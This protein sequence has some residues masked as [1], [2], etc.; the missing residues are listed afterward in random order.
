MAIIGIDLGTS[1]SAAAALRGG[2]PM[3]I[4]SAEGISL[5]GKSFPSYVAVTADGQMLVGEPARRQAVANP[6]G[7]ATCFKRRMGQRLAVRLQD[8]EF[9]PEQLSAFLLQKIKRYA[10]AYLGEPVVQAVV[11]V[12]AYFDDNQRSATKDACAVAGIE[13]ARLVNEPTAASLAYGLDR[14]GEELRVAVVDLGGGT[15]DVTILEFGQGVFVVKSTSGDTHLGG[16]DMDR[17]V[18]DHLAAGFRDQTG[19][20]VRADT[21][22]AARLR[23]AAEVAKVELST[24]VTTHVSLPYLVAIAGEA[25]H[26]E[27][28]LSRAELERL[29]WPVIERCRA[30]VQ[31][32]LA[33]ASVTPAQI[34]RLVFVGGPT[35]MPAVRAFFEDLLGQHAE[36][37][38]DPMECV[39]VGAA[40]QAAVLSGQL[41]EIVLVDVTPLTLGVETLGGVATPLVERNTPIPVCKTET[42][43]T[44]ADMQTSVSVHVVQGERP[45]AADDT[46]LGQFN[47][48]GL[49][50]APRGVPQIE[51]T[52]DIDV[53]GI[54]KATALDVATGRAQSI[55]I[56]G[57]TRLSKEEKERMIAEAER[58]AEEDRRRHEDAVAL[59]DADSLCYQAERTQADFGAKLSVERR[60]RLESAYRETK[61]AVSA[62]NPGEA[63]TR[64]ERLKAV[65]QEAGTILY[66]AA[67]ATR[68]PETQAPP[69]SPPPEGG[70]RVVNAQYQ[71][72]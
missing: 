9:T 45:M 26:L 54:L 10:E 13:V 17:R 62:H 42:F 2:R 34:D 67:A 46:T 36:S 39:A 56:T 57:S 38:V 15:L 8:R 5:G 3:T 25:Q 48:D 66:T 33:D 59:N 12:P 16:A 71:E 7:T 20:D 22:A 37:C 55:R 60:Q 43:T 29:V 1:N 23:E 6:E 63:K 52:F 49:P 11:T 18:F 27:L 69:G 24:A 31:Q 40:I 19:V 72:V 68:P 30:P 53:D 44:A 61:E 70:R 58:Y 4:P 65:L 32:A 28:D 51:L 21:R 50:L 64:S 14:A 47:L 35:R 41:G